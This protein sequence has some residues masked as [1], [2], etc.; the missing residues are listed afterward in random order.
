[1]HYDFFLYGWIMP[2]TD[3]KDYQFSFHMIDIKKIDPSPYQHRKYFDKNSLKELGASIL[4]DGLIEPI[5][6]RPQKK[7]RY[8]LIAGERRL[9]AIKDYTDMTIIQAKIVLVDD[10]RA[11]RISATENL[12]RK[13]LSAIESIEATIEIIDVEM[14]KDAD[15]LTV[16]K[17]PLE[18]VHKMLSKLDSIRVSKDRGSMVSDETSD[19]FYKYVEQVESIFKNLP[20]PLKWLSFLLHDLTLL[21]D[22]PS[23][24]QKASV[25]YDLNKAQT[26]ALARLEQV[27]DRAFHDV[28]QK[29]F[30]PFKDKN[31]LL[32]KLKLNEFSAREI[33][34]FAENLEKA[35]QKKEQKKDEH[36]QEFRTE[37]KVALMILLG[38]PLVRI[39]RR[40]NTHRETIAKYARK[41]DTLFNE[42][43]QDFKGGACIPDIAQK[44]IIPQTLAWSVVLQEKTDQ[45]RFKDLNWGLR[46]WDHRSF[47]N[48]DHRFGDH[49]PG[50]ISG[51]NFIFC[52]LYLD[53]I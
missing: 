46:T 28:T 38:I 44:Y 31:N 11:R 51:K 50:R 10:L 48:V 36:Q 43:L 16:G 20:K 27:S 9:R 13:D 12:L 21:T 45:E 19:L 30:I 29:N 41:N 14:G 37:I 3:N 24:V 49:W 22:I 15:Y 47:N 33:R 18:R 4:R 5:I 17:T 32:P 23:K 8:Q 2:I 34:G 40:L 53:E 26:K 39:A 35:N 42:I 1:M 25:K 7:G 6:V 52:F